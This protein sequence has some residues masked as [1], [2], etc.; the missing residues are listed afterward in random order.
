MLYQDPGVGSQLVSPLSPLGDAKH[1]CSFYLE[2]ELEP[3]SE[4][5]IDFGIIG[6]ENSPKATWAVPLRG[7]DLCTGEIEVHL[8]IY[9]VTHDNKIH[10][11]NKFFANSMSPMKFGGLFHVGVEILDTEWAYGWT[12]SGTGVTCGAPRGEQQHHFRETVRLC[13]TKLSKCE[14]EGVLRRLLIE[15]Q[16]K[17]YHMIDRNCCRFAEDLCH[18]LG[19]GAIPAWVQRMCH[20]CEGLLKAFSVDGQHLSCSSQSIGP[21]T[22]QRRSTHQGFASTPDSVASSRNMH[23]EI[24]SF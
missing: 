7:I 6:D 20:I 21:D 17:E 24:L 3:E 16:G 2:S 14:V 22:S 11:I 8:N 10:Q 13:N 15:Y 12:K 19:V 5:V 4:S 23:R 1:L 9:D 18:R